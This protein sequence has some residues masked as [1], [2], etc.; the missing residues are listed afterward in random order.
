MHTHLRQLRRG[1]DDTEDDGS[2]D[3]NN[4]VLEPEQGN[5]HRNVSHVAIVVSHE[6]HPL[7]EVKQ[8]LRDILQKE[9]DSDHDVESLD[10]VLIFLHVVLVK[11]VVVD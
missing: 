1:N 11:S 8:D 2:N 6:R 3:R 9:K 4:D 10:D 5:L 7:R